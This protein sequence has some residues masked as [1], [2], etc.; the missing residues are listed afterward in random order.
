VRRK[1][2]AAALIVTAL[3]LT[4][5]AITSGVSKWRLEAARRA[6]TA[7]WAP[8]LEVVKQLQMTGRFQEA[9][10]VLQRLPNADVGDLNDQIRGALAE[11]DLAQNLDRIRHNRAAVVDGRFDLDSNRT[12]SDREYE[13]TFGEAGIGGFHDARSVAAARVRGSHIR[14]ALVA[15]LD[16][17][18][19]C[20]NDE[21]RRS[22]I[23]AVAR[24]ADPD[25]GGWR[26]RVRAPVLSQKD[27]TELADA[28]LVQDQSVQV[29]V[30]LAQRMQ[31]A[32]ADAIA[33]LGRVQ[34]QYAGDF[35]ASFTLADALWGKK[36]AECIRYYQAALAIRPE[37]V[38]AHHNVG[39][40]LAN[41]GRIEEAI[42][43]IETAIQLDAQMLYA[44][45][46]LPH[47]WRQKQ[48][49]QKALIEYNKAIELRPND[50]YSIQAR[51]AVMVQ[52]GLGD[53]V[54]AEW[55]HA[56]K[57]NP[58]GHAAWYGYAEMCLY[59]G[60][61]DEYKRA[62]HEL[63]AR[64]ESS[65]D[66]RVCEQT[67]RACLL[68][69]VGPEMTTRA[70]AAL[71]E[72]A[73]QACTPAWAIP[74]FSIAQGLARYRL[75][76]FDSAVRAIHGDALRVHGPLPDERTRPSAASRRRSVTTTGVRPEWTVTT[77]GFTTHCAE[78]P[79]HWSCRT[80]RHCSRVKSNPVTMMSAWH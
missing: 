42:A 50:A 69:I 49:P 36:P 19:L 32:G 40:A 57:A 65:T 10:A 30:A 43:E 14:T 17:W 23:F 3:A 79:S 73:V 46:L 12:R 63:L 53:A 1:P 24:G 74:Y 27:L 28:A 2:T 35:W 7:R 52:L 60:H 31:A 72:R 16:D 38:L 34:Q 41:A 5:L 11:L 59:L 67:G 22:W 76:D 15:A 78:R 62:C 54:R 9:R 39:R 48:S 18:A 77:P 26:D 51:R 8:R 80:W 33:F 21:S 20:T 6:E 66:P 29:L 25:P 75:G 71:V 64:F 58:P 4:G 68:G 56:L 13:A 55:G 47:C 44:H 45:S 70:A 61:E 37:T